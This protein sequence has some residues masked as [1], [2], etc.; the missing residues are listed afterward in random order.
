M[1]AR[2]AAQRLV[3][4]PEDIRRVQRD[5]LARAPFTRDTGVTLACFFALRG[6]VLLPLK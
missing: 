4:D 6:V 5:V 3:V 1:S 2:R